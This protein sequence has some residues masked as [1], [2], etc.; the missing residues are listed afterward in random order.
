MKVRL[1]HF[2][3]TSQKNVLIMMDH[4]NGKILNGFKFKNPKIQKFELE[5]GLLKL[6]TY[7]QKINL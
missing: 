7:L 5:L 6:K 1:S 2:K 3:F 4:S